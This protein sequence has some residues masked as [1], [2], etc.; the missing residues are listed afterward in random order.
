[1]KSKENQ[2]SFIEQKK[3]YD[4]H[5]ND[6]SNKGYRAYFQRFLDFVLPIEPTP[7]YALD[8]GCGRSTLV[9]DMLTQKSIATDYYDPIYHPNKVYKNSSYDLILSIEVFEH[10]HNP[11]DIFSTL[12]KHLNSDGYIAIQTA[13]RP[14]TK[15]EFL[16]WYYRLDPTHLIFFS[17]KSLSILASKFGMRVI[18][19]DGKQMVVLGSL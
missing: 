3:R 9:T 5:Q 12:V 15:E 11:K 4:L 10:L 2:S 13:F 8:F 16:E 7:R 6:S 1:M 19:D 14:D 17:P 18:K